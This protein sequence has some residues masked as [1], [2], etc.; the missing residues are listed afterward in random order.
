M[1]I[2]RG[3]DEEER[4]EVLE[5]GTDGE[6]GEEEVASDDDAEAEDNEGE[7]LEE[8]AHMRRGGANGHTQ[9][10]KK[11][12][13]GADDTGSPSFLHMQINELLAETREDYSRLI[14]LNRA[15]ADLTNTISK[16]KEHTV[17]LSSAEEFIAA[18]GVDRLSSFTFRA[19]ELIKVIGSYALRTVAKPVH[20][21][22]IALL[23]PKSCFHEKDFLNHRYHTKRALYL[24]AIAQQLRKKS[25]VYSKVL[26][27]ASSR[28]DMRL[29]V[30]VL[31]LAQP[32]TPYTIRLHPLVSPD[33]FLHNKLAVQ[34]NN[35]RQC[36]KDDSPVPTPSYSNSILGDMRILN[37]S[38]VLRDVFANNPAMVWSRQRGM[39]K[40]SDS[41][42]GFLWSM[43][44]VHL[45]QI[46]RI[47]AHMDAYHMF[48]VVLDVV[49]NTE[50][51]EKGV[52][53]RAEGVTTSSDGRMAMQ[54]AF[55][56]VFVDGDGFN[57]AAHVSKTAVQ[58]LKREAKTT[59]ANLM[60]SERKGS[61][62]EA[63]EA[64]FLTPVSYALKFDYHVSVLLPVENIELG[65]VD[66][67]TWR[68]QER[69]VE[70][71][72][73]Q[74][75]SDRAA[76]VRVFPRPNPAW[77]TN[78]KGL[79]ALEPAIDVG[80]VLAEG[81]AAL[82]LVDIGPAADKKAE[83]KAFRNFWGSRAELRRFKDGLIAESVVW[84]CPAG[85][86]HLIIE[87][88]CRHILQR[89][90]SVDESAVH[91]VAGQLDRVL[92]LG[93]DGM[94]DPS[95]VEPIVQES[96]DKLSKQLRNLSDL[97]L[98]IVSLQPLSAVL[99]HADVFPPQPHPLARGGGGSRKLHDELLD[100]ST[101]PLCVHPIE[102]LL[103]LEGSGKWPNDT[104]ALRH[105]KAAFCLK[106]AESLRATA[107][108]HTVVAQD[109]YLDVFHDG[110]AFRVHILCE[111]EVALQRKQ[112]S[113]QAALE[114]SLRHR[115]VHAS[116][117][118]G[119]HGQYPAFGPS[120][121]LAKRWVSAHMFGNQVCEEAVELLMARVFTQPQPF[122][123]PRSRITA[124]IRFLRVLTGHDWHQFPLI[125]DARFDIKRKLPGGGP[126]MFIATPQD[127]ESNSWTRHRP[128]TDVLKRLNAYARTSSQLLQQLIERNEISGKAW[129]RLFR[130]PLVS[131]DALLH[132]R[133]EALPRWQQTLFSTS[134]LA[135]TMQN[136]EAEPK[137]NLRRMPRTALAKGAAAR[138]ALLVG[139][140]PVHEYLHKLVA[141]YGSIARFHYDV[142]GGDVIGVTW[143]P[144]A[145]KR[146]SVVAESGQDEAPAK[147]RKTNSG[148]AAPYVLP[149]VDLASVVE[150]FRTTG[151]G[152]VAEV[153]G[154]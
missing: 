83:A 98:K 11:Q 106:I 137:I 90:F 121:R 37:H 111:Q 147:R 22:D 127:K 65:S 103:E 93:K 61:G 17:N 139:F 113:E 7:E 142:Y 68:Q 88:M 30:L 143:R 140:D 18:L 72:L 27:E 44:L 24:A 29:P 6:D 43:L 57:M 40:S 58:D 119:L 117:L 89:H 148:K 86:R 154:A 107:G 104:E 35:L 134:S 28:H 112:Q 79:P 100:G 48:R 21:I 34:R 87:R 75:L 46:S 47:N 141:S 149:M 13:E 39:H 2:R 131:Y 64:T 85:E 94:Q 1:A 97:P 145:Y 33:A 138:D 125:V 116:Q 95:A 71:V 9:G 52:F 73:K 151:R 82:R 120:V 108:M 20:N 118:S 96:F 54:Q 42:S 31:T 92:L 153:H 91:V 14:Q 23:M 70:V 114:E 56:V 51:L 10:K 5:G 25:S 26:Y 77:D 101:V 3:R 63:F 8:D 144:E 129:L 50:M 19:P 78:Q 150:Q 49:A 12:V 66:V 136:G 124:L 135:S 122:G 102:L 132:L 110:F 126:A 152:L 80:I 130:T 128:D 105:M 81:D 99:R 15:V 76:F 109:P 123:L 36:V 59:L 74:A 41:F 45:Q 53:M 62:E 60:D 69:R 16:M 133:R 115:S 67:P 38:Q 55:E 4:E 146:V 84:E 32:T